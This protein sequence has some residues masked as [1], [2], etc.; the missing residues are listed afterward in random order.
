MKLLTMEDETGWCEVTLF[1]RAY[2]DHG[3]VLLGDGPKLLEGVV[4]ED[5]GI[6]AIT[7]ERLALRQ[8]G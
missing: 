3:H 8:A 5:L 6:Y 4:V 2:Q 7:V 1:P